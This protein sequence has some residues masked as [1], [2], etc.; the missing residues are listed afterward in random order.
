MRDEAGEA[1]LEAL[2]ARAAAVSLA[3]ITS[4]WVVRLRRG[5]RGVRRRLLRRRSRRGGDASAQQLEVTTRSAARA[6]LDAARGRE[7]PPGGADSAR[8]IR[9]RATRCGWW[10]STTKGMRSTW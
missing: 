10:C 1:R 5:V 2:A 7:E 6:L 4:G 3:S 9:A 8:V